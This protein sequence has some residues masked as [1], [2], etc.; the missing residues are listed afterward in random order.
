M[1]HTATLRCLI[2]V[3]ISAAPAFAA[4][5]AARTKCLDARN[6]PDQTIQ[7]CTLIID[8]RTEVAAEKFAAYLRRARAHFAKQDWDHSIIDY[9]SA[10][11]LFPNV[12]GAY[13]E[14]GAAYD[15]KGNRD[16]AIADY[17]T[18]IR[19]DPNNSLAY[20]N[21]GLAH[22]KNEAY[23]LAIGDFDEAI[24]LDAKYSVAFNG[25]GVV[26]SKK[27]DHQ[28]AIADFTEAI[29]LSPFYAIAYNNR[30]TARANIGNFDEAIADLQVAVRL[31]DDP[32]F[33]NELAWTYF[34]A[35]QP[36]AGLPYADHALRINP[37]YANGYDTRGSI[38]ESLGK[39]INAIADFKRALSL[40]PS[41]AS[42]AAALARL[43][44][45]DP[46]S[47]T[48]SDVVQ[49]AHRQGWRISLGDMCNKF[50]LSWSG[51]DCAFQQLSVQETEGR[52]GLRG[53]NVPA[54]SNSAPPYV[55]IFHLKP[56]VGEFFV[57]SPD[58]VLMR[59]FLRFKGTDYSR[60]SNEEMRQEFNKDLAYWTENFFRLKADLEAKGS[61]RK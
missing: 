55:L 57:V 8:D 24:R 33:Y 21:R 6:S 36:K 12:A 47:V 45:P 51:N 61:G 4:N 14:R 38:Y 7:S 48:F 42:S 50:E 20:A 52:N 56:L 43:A 40:D 30:G 32:K 11:R 13:N 34:R 27:G 5:D 26:Y 59:A 1:P 2:A 19:I 44:Q 37:D 23:D 41:I 22:Y 15:R 28:K 10:I 17:S 54:A 3:L 49:F 60:V 29:R 39:P 35:G 25:R 31:K 58:G 18:A 16:R 53:L 9:N 46:A